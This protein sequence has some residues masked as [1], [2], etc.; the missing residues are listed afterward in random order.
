MTKLVQQINNKYVFNHNCRII[1]VRASNMVNAEKRLCK[2][3]KR[4]K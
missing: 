4:N 3:L 1:S 2:Q